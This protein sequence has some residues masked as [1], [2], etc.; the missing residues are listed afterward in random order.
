MRPDQ[1]LG[2][3]LLRLVGYLGWG[4][5][6]PPHLGVAALGCCL[7]QSVRHLVAE[8]SQAS[9]DGGGGG[10]GGVSLEARHPLD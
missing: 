9:V 2:P 7:W 6:E 8:S 3:V 4:C 5:F 10:G 1:Q